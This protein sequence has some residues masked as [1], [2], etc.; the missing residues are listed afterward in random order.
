MPEV[1]DAQAG[2]DQQRHRQRALDALGA[3]ERVGL[4][5]RPRRLC[6]REGQQPPDVLGIVELLEP[7]AVALA[8]GARLL[9][10]EAAADQVDVLLRRRLDPDEVARHV[11]QRPGDAERRRRARIAGADIRRQEVPQPVL[12]VAAL[13]EHREAGDGL[14]RQEVP[15]HQRGA[16]A[17]EEARHS[18]RWS[19]A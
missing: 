12:E 19:R 5:Q 8:H 10:V 15:P 1:L 6:L 7:V 16:E 13:E 17:A 11:A 9:R 4:A 3:A 2:E 18:R 14:D